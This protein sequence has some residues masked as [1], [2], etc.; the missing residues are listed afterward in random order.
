VADIA[1]RGVR[2]GSALRCLHQRAG[3]LRLD[4]K[5]SDIVCEGGCAKVI[6]FSIARRPGPGHRGA[7]T[8]HYLAPEQARG[9]EVAPATDVWGIG[10]VLFE[11][12]TGRRAFAAA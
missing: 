3:F 12:A 5:P 10:V 9:D 2:V 1:P 6:D 7:G 8:L 11:A 4:L